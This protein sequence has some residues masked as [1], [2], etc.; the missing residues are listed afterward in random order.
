MT[1]KLGLRALCLVYLGLLIIGPVAVMLWQTFSGGVAPV[2]EALT[3]PAFLH[4]L[5]LTLIIALIAVP[6]NTIFGVLFAMPSS[7]TNFAA[8]RS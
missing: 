2:L 6:L 3:R 8:S 4:A 7:A 1:G 5:K